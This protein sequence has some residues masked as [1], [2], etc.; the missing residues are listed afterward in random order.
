MIYGND[1]NIWKRSSNIYQGNEKGI[2][3][4]YRSNLWDKPL[5]NSRIGIY[6]ELL[7]TNEIN[8]V[9]SCCKDIIGMF[10]Y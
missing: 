9:N 8:E 10:N 5:N 2:V 6:K 7:E 4:P 3:N 1:F